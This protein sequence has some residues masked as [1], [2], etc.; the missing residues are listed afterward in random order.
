MK[1]TNEEVYKKFVVV[2]NSRCDLCFGEDKECTIIKFNWFSKKK[3][4]E[5]CISKLFRSLRKDK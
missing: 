3:L 4:C 5:S 1:L 2:D